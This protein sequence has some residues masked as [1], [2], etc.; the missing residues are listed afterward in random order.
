MGGERSQ[1]LRFGECSVRSPLKHPTHYM[2]RVFAQGWF[3]TSQPRE[4]AHQP[5]RRRRRR[6]SSRL[7]AWQRLF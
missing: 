4:G 3:C 5:A 1:D 6:H 2:S 7:S